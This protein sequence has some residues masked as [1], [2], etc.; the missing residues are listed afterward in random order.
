MKTKLTISVVLLFL[1]VAFISRIPTAEESGNSSKHLHPGSSN[2]DNEFIIGALHNACDLYFGYRNITDTFHMNMWHKYT[3]PIGWGWYRFPPYPFVT[4]HPDD[5]W[6]KDTNDYGPNVRR[7]IDSNNAHGLRTIMDRP[8]IQ[9]FA[10][11]QRSDYQCETDSHIESDLLFYGYDTHPPNSNIS[12]YE[13]Y[14]TFGTGEW[15]RYCDADPENPGEGSGY[16]VKDLRANHEQSNKRFNPW[17][18]DSMYAWYIK[19]RIRID[20]NFAHNNQNDAVCRVEI[21]DWHGS[22]VKDVEILGR[23]FLFNNNYDGSYIIE[24]NFDIQDSNL[25][26]RPGY[27]LC[28]WPDSGRSFGNWDIPIKTDYRI[29]WYGNCDMWI[30]YIRVENEPSVELYSGIYDERIRK[31]FQRTF[32]DYDAGIQYVKVCELNNLPC[33]DYIT[34]V[35][36]LRQAPNNFSLIVYKPFYFDSLYKQNIAALY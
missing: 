31:E 29:Y 15:V 26:V 5:R 22:K 23:H 7:H 14:S 1:T 12:D 21:I 25:V 11:G 32:L 8:V 27:R 4:S 30:D 35:L 13:D 36:S 24:F 3:A 6:D 20:S 28:P 9:Y 16:V 17:A 10:Y 34:R 2:P 33:I 19:P 18:S